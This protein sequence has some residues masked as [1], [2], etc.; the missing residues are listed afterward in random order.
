V[1]TAADDREFF[2]SGCQDWVQAGGP[3]DQWHIGATVPP[4]QNG[5]P[6][7]KTAAANGDYRIGLPK[8]WPSDPGYDIQWGLWGIPTACHWQR[9]RDWSGDSGSV[10]ASGVG[11]DGIGPFQ[12]TLLIDKDD[13]G[14]RLYD[15]PLGSTL[16]YY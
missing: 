13:V 9:L 16:Y 4:N 5:V 14:V 1:Q 2:T 10:I 12:P 15:C 11:G 6:L 8:V 7:I 3:D